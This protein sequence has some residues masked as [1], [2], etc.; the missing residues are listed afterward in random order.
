M[1]G[2]GFR[3]HHTFRDQNATAADTAP[4]DTAALLSETESTDPLRIVLVGPPYF[5]IPPKAY[6]GTEA[7]VADLADS[8]TARGHR[9]TVLGAAHPRIA[10]RFLPLWARPLPARLG[11]ADP[12]LPNPL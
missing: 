1:S 3:F 10:A 6:G 8:L 11:H 12:V 5:D 4:A 2:N 9:D 7:V